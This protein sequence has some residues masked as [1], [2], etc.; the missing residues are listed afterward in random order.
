MLMPRLAIPEVELHYE[1]R[2][3]GPVLLC[4]PGALGTGASDFAP[5]IEGLSHRFRIIAPDPR[6]YG[7]SRPPQRDFPADFLQRDAND[8][9]ALL[10]ALGVASCCVA[11]WS[12]GANTAA[13]LAIAHPHRVARLAIWGGNSYN[14]AQDVALYQEARS[15]DSWS[16][17]MRQTYAAIY[18]EELQPLWSAWCDALDSIYAAGGEIY[19]RRLCEIRCPT[20]IL[21]GALDPIVPRFHA[22]ELHRGIAGSR[23]HVFAEGKHNI[24]L[25]YAVEFNRLLEEFMGAGS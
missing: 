14:A 24:H 4:L 17:R 23:L 15:L 9:A 7:Q 12:D 18:G 20:L 8:M 10:E 6:G 25:R 21:D 11:G 19:R 13:L 2:G 5:Q 3:R 22:Q 1:D 16:P